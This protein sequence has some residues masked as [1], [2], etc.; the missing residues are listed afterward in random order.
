MYV[1]K[2][3]YI[4][5]YIIYISYIIFIFIYNVKN[6]IILLL[7]T[8]CLPTIRFNHSMIFFSIFFN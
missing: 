4:W 2:I 1:L 6:A 7:P 8:K 3:E 5:L